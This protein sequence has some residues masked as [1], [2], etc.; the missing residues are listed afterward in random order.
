MNIAVLVSG[1]GTNLQAIIDLVNNGNIKA[2]IA[3]VVSNNPDAYA[4]IRAAN[5]G[6]ETFVLS[7]KGFSRREEYD[8]VLIDE[9]EKRNVE[10]VVLAGF[11]RLV[12]SFFVEKYRYNILNIHNK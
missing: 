3:L 12:S 2:H 5:A 6:I 4:L 10:L 1:D 7:H 11:M 9:L 8:K